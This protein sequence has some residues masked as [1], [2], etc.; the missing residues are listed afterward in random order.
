MAGIRHEDFILFYLIGKKELRGVFKAIE[1]PFFDDKQVWDF[2]EKE[3]LYPSR[4][5]FNNSY[6]SFEK[7]IMLSDIYDLRDNGKI[8]TF[9]LKRPA[10]P[11]TNAM[12]SI[13][14]HEFEELLNLYL[15]FNPVY[16][17]PKQIREPYPYFE[18]NLENRLTCDSLTLEPKYEYTLMSLLS[19]AVAKNR[20]T[21]IFGSYSDYL[22]YIP[23][24]FE[25]EI[26]MI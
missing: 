25:Q 15:K 2:T 20:F 5:R 6:Y 3:Q 10:S 22:S 11:A 8:W 24:S 23:T 12:F 19:F 7:P 18:A 1:G 16:S 4:I 13:S 9:S 14:N 21:D 26:D 17:Q